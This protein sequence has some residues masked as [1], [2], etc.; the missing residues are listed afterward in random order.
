MNALNCWV[1]C[2]YVY[3]YLLGSLPRLL[4]LLK[5][6]IYQLTNLNQGSGATDVSR[7]KTDGINVFLSNPWKEGRGQEGEIGIEIKNTLLCI[8]IYDTLPPQPPSKKN[9]KKKKNHEKKIY[10]SVC[11]QAVPH[12]LFFFFPFSHFLSRHIFGL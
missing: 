10:R 7:Q 12:S 6:R 11:K 9:I 4:F 8:I 3:Y 5:L 2:S 1:A